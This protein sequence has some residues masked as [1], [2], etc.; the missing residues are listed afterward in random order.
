MRE[1]SRNGMSHARNGGHVGHEQRDF[2]LRGLV[3]FAA[4]LTI[5]CAITGAAVLALFRYLDQRLV[6]AEQPVSP[7]ALP[8]GQLPPEPRL[9]TNEPANLAAY[10][11]AQEERLTTYGWV[12]K[13]AGIVRIPIARAKELILERGLPTR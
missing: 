6:E 5:V 12:D 8:S 1:Q 2:S 11:Q 4:G 13:D 7:M 3:L 10:R 9:L